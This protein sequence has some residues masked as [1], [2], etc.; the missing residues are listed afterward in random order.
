MPQPKDI[1]CMNGYEN[2]THIY[3]LQET[4]FTSRETYKLKVRGWKK[5]FHA[6]ETKIIWSRSSHCG[7]VETNPISIHEDAGMTPSLTQY[8]KDHIA[9]SCGIGHRC[10]LDPMLLWLWL[11][12]VAQIQPLAWIL[13]YATV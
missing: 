10:G 1:D 4:H 7:T 11:A 12:S 8:V 13:S 9:L 6:M 3:C 5:I 2:K